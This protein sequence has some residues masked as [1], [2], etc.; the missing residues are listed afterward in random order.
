MPEYW[1]SRAWS[2]SHSDYFTRNILTFGDLGPGWSSAEAEAYAAWSPNNIRPTWPTLDEAT[3]WAESINNYPG[4]GA[5]PRLNV[6]NLQL[7]L[8]AAIEYHAARCHIHVRP[9][10]ATGAVDP[11]GDPVE[12]PAAVKLA[13]IKRAVRWARRAM[14]PDGIAGGGDITGLIRTSSLDPDIE[15]ELA[16]WIMPGLY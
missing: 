14:T 16:P 5:T 6:E 7:C 1:T 13:T 11:D 8:D 12:I 4:V 9:V 3:R 15:A 10:D 2:D